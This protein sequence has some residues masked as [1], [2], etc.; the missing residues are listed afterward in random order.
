[1]VSQQFLPV[2][3]AYFQTVT[4]LQDDGERTSVWHLKTNF[5]LCIDFA[6]EALCNYL[7]ISS[8]ESKLINS[9]SQ[10]VAWMKFTLSFLVYIL[11]FSNSKT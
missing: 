1:M 5:A 9:Y 11:Q 10:P 4:R 2:Q 7:T 6:K 8:S 3:T